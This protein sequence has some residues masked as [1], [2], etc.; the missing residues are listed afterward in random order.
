MATKALTAVARRASRNHVPARKARAHA[1]DWRELLISQD[2]QA[3]WSKL[4]LLVRSVAAE[5]S[6]NQDSI[7]QDLFLLLLSTD[8]F[9]LYIRQGFSSEEIRS[10][11]VSFLTS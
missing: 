7:T 10:D 5:H 2:A 3:I 8:R 1:Q 4:S 9:N 11:I 6:D